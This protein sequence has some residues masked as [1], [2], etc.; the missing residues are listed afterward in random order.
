MQ[1][2]NYSIHLNDVQ[3]S[4]YWVL[5]AIRDL[6]IGVT[7]RQQYIIKIYLL[8]QIYFVLS[9]IY[10]WWHTGFSLKV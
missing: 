10:V 6:T 5:T 8:L 4:C 7:R 1:F 2:N 3:N 9:R